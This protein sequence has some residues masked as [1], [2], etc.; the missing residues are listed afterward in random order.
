VS[1][2][3]DV[4]RLLKRARKQGWRVEESGR[5][6][7][8]VYPLDP[9]AAPITVAR[10]PGDWRNIRNLNADFKRAGLE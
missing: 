5:R 8:R 10:S 3:K 9:D 4:K 6:H 2:D 1:Q 7:I